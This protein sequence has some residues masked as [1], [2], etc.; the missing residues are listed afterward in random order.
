M[1]D[2]AFWDKAAPKYA[3]D[4]ISDMDGYT[5]TLNRMKEILQ[6]HHRVLEIGCGTGS[7][8]LE[9]APNVDRY[10]GTDISAGMIEIAQSKQA[11][12]TPSHLRFAVHAADDIPAAPHDVILALNLLH[13]LPNLEVTLDRIYESLPAGGIFIAKTGLLKDGK[14]FLPL[15][16]PVMRA[17]GKAPYVRSMKQAEFIELLKAAGFDVTETLLQPGIAPRLFTVARKP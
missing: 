6:P 3:R 14:W 1:T 15:M 12:E 7:T 8:A 11:L 17:I 2:A 5:A 10:I 16:I 9:L 4:P 13:L